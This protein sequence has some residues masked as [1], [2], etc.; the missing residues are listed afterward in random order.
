MWGCGGLGL[1]ARKEGD[2]GNVRGK[3]KSVRAWGRGLRRGERGVG[4]YVGNWSKMPI[5]GTF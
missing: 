4:W 1:S 3:R 5:L 2:L